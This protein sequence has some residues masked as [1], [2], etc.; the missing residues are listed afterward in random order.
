MGK[1]LTTSSQMAC[2]HAGTV[3]V[4]CGNTK[5]KAGDWVLRATDTFTIS[6][7]TF[8][9]PGPKPSPCL[10]VQW[11]VSDVKVRVAGDKSLSTGSLGLCLSADM[12]PQ[13]MVNITGT[14]SKVS[15]T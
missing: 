15:S 7:C 13:G 6:G 4:V 8:T 12:I 5:V 1:T 9:L 2:P 3:N 14:Q 10:K 11:L